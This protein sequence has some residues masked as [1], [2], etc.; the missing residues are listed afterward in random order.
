MALKITFAQSFLC[1]CLL[2]F[3]WTWQVASLHRALFLTGQPDQPYILKS[4][5]ED[6]AHL[7]R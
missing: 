2:A 4:V 7:S 6:I 3:P 1:L 5:G